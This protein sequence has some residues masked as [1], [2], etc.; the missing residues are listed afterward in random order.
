MRRF[1]PL[2]VV[3]LLACAGTA[4]PGQ[5]SV[6][7]GTGEVHELGVAGAQDYGSTVFSGAGTLR[8]TGAGFVTWGGGSTTFA[9]GSGSRLEVQGGVFNG[10]SGW[11]ENWTNNKSDLSVVS[12]AAF[13]GNEGSIR[14]DALSGSGTITAGWGGLGSLTFG[15]DNG[16]GRF[17]GTLADGGSTGHFIKTGTGAQIIERHATYTGTTTVASGTLLFEQTVASTACNVSSGAILAFA[18]A[19][20]AVQRARRPASL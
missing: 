8:K 19:G 1:R 2:A 7:I 15:V 6:V 12:G 10:S 4:A 3:A 11:D 13:H 20:A 18:P 9:L 5:T 14:V 17:S 16:G